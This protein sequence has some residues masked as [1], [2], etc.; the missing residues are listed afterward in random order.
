MKRFLKNYR[1]SVPVALVPLTAL[2]L[3][4]TG[5]FVGRDHPRSGTAVVLG[6]DDGIRFLRFEQFET[7]TGPD[8]T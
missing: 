6:D 8:L 5:D 4:A 7:D 2:A 3:L 1:V